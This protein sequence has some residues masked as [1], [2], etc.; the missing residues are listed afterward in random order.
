MS[1][2]IITDIDSVNIKVE[3]ERGIAKELSD[4]FTFKV[5]G[6][7]YMP[8]YRNKVW[9]GQI[10]LYNL[11]SQQIYRGL[12]DYVVKF[13]HD[14]GYKVFVDRK[15]EQK[16]N[17]SKEDVRKFIN[18]FLQPCAAGEKIT[19]HEHQVD[20]VVHA[21]NNDRCLLLS[22]TGSGKSLIIY[23]LIRYFIDKIPEDKKLLIIVPTT[24]L[25][26]QMYNDFKDYSSNS[27]WSADKNCHMAKSGVTKIPTN[28]L[29]TTEDGKH[30]SFEG[31]DFIKLIN[32]KKNKKLAKELSL[33]DEIDDKWLS[34][35]TR[36]QVL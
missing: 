22:P 26:A 17:I 21:I 24:G 16:T 20:A 32:N 1:D 6:H 18:D 33:D 14:R 19:A 11:Y 13:A 5:P 29:I 28:Y 2:I 12:Y 3:C 4:F 30:Y 27:D 31:N 15:S 7:Q 35:Q 23:A 8:S 25:V 34:E 36:K 9:D 10:K